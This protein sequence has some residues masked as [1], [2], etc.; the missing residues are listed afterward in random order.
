MWC[1]WLL[2]IPLLE[3]LLH[4]CRDV[5]NANELFQVIAVMAALASSPEDIPT[6]QAFAS[7]LPLTVLADVVIANMDHMPRREDVAGAQNASSGAGA[8][9]SL[10]HVRM[11]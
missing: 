5:T 3:Q 2:Q 6:L 4:Q 1:P 9:A 7:N 8:L 10:M 11:S